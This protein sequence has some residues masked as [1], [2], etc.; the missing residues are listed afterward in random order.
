MIKIVGNVWLKISSKRRLAD[1]MMKKSLIQV[2]KFLYHLID[3]LML[4][5][6]IL[7]V[8]ESSSDVDENNLPAVEEDPISW[9]EM[10]EKIRSEEE[11]EFICAYCFIGIGKEAHMLCANCWEMYHL[12]CVIIIV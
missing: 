7:E 12:C 1:S 4:L 3:K 8:S 2:F 5:L 11:E 6:Y 10:D 9:I